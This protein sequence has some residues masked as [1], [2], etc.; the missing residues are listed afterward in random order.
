MHG[1][2]PVVVDERVA[3]LRPL[4]EQ[5]TADLARWISGDEFEAVFD[6][7]MRA[8]LALTFR[9]V[10]ADEGSVWLLDADGEHLVPRY[11]SGP[12]ATSF[13]GRFRQSVRSGMIS[14]VVA[15]QQ[16]ICENAMF[17]NPRQDRS[18]DQQLGLQ[19]S[20]MLAAPL[21]FAKELRGVISC[22]QLTE[23]GAREP[24]PGF[25]PEALEALSLAAGILSRLIDHRLRELALGH[26]EPG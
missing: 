20:A 12:N 6:S 24:R 7:S 8:M 22:V 5:Q 19:T 2:L 13:V 14:M 21:L 17:R 26:S 11:N 18:L 15:T 3:Q 1:R 23:A 9:S 4:L 16:P 25:T 10:G